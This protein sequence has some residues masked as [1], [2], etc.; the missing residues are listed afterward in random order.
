MS[1]ALKCNALCF[2]TK[3]TL[4]KHMTS[5]T[6][7]H[8]RPL[9]KGHRSRSQRLPFSIFSIHALRTSKERTTSLYKGQ[10][11]WIYIV[12][13]LS[14]VQRFHW[15]NAPSLIPR[16]LASAW[17]M[18]SWYYNYCSWLQSLLKGLGT[19]RRRFALLESMQVALHNINLPLNT[20]IIRGVEK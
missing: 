16:P 9:Y 7:Y 14:L 1:T 19:R 6:Y 3:L 11:S 17:A 13:K 12:P 18:L 4:V 8:V 2:V 5:S 20:W 15:V 10:N